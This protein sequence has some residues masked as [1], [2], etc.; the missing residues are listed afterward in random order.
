ML[1]KH[2]S[3]VEDMLLYN[4]IKCLD[5]EIQYTRIIV[6]NDSVNEEDLKAWNK[7][8]DNYLDVYGL[9]DLAK[10]LM[11]LNKKLAIAQNDY[12]ISE[13]RFV[14]NAVRVLSSEI[15]KIKSQ[16]NKGLSHD[17]VLIHLSKFMGFKLSSKKI[18]VK[19][20]LDLLI[21]HERGN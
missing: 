14:L 16:M 5:G 17:K 7:I 1:E 4:W 10:R 6:N 15:E 9:N 21:E 12:I 8:Y 13:N 20:Y 2:Y 18:T 19:E 11:N 3:G